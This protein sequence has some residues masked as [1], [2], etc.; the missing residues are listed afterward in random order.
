MAF[1]KHGRREMKISYAATY[2]SGIRCFVS[3]TVGV[4]LEWQNRVKV[5]KSF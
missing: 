4:L 2:V 3:T 5:Y 1:L